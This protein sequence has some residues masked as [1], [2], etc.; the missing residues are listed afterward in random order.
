MK[1]ANPVSRGLAAAVLVGTLAFVACAR[2]KPAAAASAGPKTVMDYF[3]IKVGGKVVRLQ[4]AIRQAEMQR[5]LMERRDLGRD[6]GMLFLYGK[7]QQMQFWMRNTPTAL[8]IGFFNPEGVLEEI[9]PLHPFD[10]KT[11]SSRSDRLQYALEMNQGWYREN[12]VKPGA[13]LDR[14]ALAEAVKARG[15]EPRRYGL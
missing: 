4:L 12:G 15:F 3:P 8:D 2:D 5:G 6:D 1:S 10:E 7:P 9:Y 14:K 13:Q 11:M